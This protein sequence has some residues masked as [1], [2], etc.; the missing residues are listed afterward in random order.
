[1]T[2]DDPLFPDCWGGMENTIF[3]SLE[4]FQATLLFDLFLFVDGR[5]KELSLCGWTSNLG[6]P[7]EL[8]Q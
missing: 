6:E 4:A 3:F 8:E 5:K 2:P 1:M 7:L